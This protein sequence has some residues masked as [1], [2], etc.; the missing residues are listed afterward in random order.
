MTWMFE[1]DFDSDTVGVRPPPIGKS[2]IA[3]YSQKDLDDAIKMARAEGYEDGRVSG[4]SEAFSSAE[5]NEAG[6]RLAALEA[7]APVML[8]LFQDADRHHATLEAQMLGFVISVFE[9][10]APEVVSALARPQ[11]ERGAR[12]AIQMAL[13]SASLRVFFPPE[14]AK[15]SGDDLLRT[16]R[17][18]GLAGRVE[19]KSD[20]ALAPGDMRAEWDHGV[21]EYSFNDICQRI[22]DALDAARIAAEQKSGLTQAGE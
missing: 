7:A 15:E 6:R 4:R 1:R 17:S 22:F 16:A 20:P 9:R 12:E 11:A 3:L 21:M 19:V 5:D 18:S 2:E 13:G 8:A 10:V 14:A